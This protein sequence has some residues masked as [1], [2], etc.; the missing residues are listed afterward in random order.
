MQQYIEANMT[1]LG[2]SGVE[3]SLQWQARQ[4]IARLKDSGLKMWICTGDKF[5]TTLAIA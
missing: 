5:E 4:T 2:L 3:D 1:Y